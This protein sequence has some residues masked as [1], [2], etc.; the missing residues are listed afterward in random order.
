MKLSDKN[1]GAQRDQTSEHFSEF[2]LERR[3]TRQPSVLFFIC[4]RQ[5]FIFEKKKR[6]K[7]KKKKRKEQRALGFSCRRRRSIHTSITAALPTVQGGRLNKAAKAPRLGGTCGC[8]WNHKQGNH[9][10]EPRGGVGCCGEEEGLRRAARG[11]GSGG[12]G[13][14]SLLVASDHRPSSVSGGDAKHVPQGR[15]RF[16]QPAGGKKKK[17]K[18]K[19]TR[20]EI[21]PTTPL[22]A[23]DGDGPKEL[24]ARVYCTHTHTH[25]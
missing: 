11:G 2:S 24:R 17:K 10:R 6:K 14:L 8:R 16:K 20:S 15:R 18:K 9:F 7:R 1:K 22:A 13:A 23:Q 21:L 5:L 19:K 12:G 4:G 3:F 25:T